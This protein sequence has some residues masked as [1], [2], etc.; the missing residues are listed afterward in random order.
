MKCQIHDYDLIGR[1]DYIGEVVIGTKLNPELLTSGKS[2]ILYG[3]IV[4]ENSTCGG[5]RLRGKF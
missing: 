3:S 5:M 4:K 1:D 2:E